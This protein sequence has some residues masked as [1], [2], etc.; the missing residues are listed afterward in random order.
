MPA[1]IAPGIETEV[2]ISEEEIRGGR[3]VAA[4]E[5]RYTPREYQELVIGLLWG[6]AAGEAFVLEHE[7]FAHWAC[8]APRTEDRF[9][10]VTTIKEELE[11]ALEGWRLLR[12][13]DDLVDWKDLL[14]TQPKGSRYE[15]FRHPT[16]DWS[17]FAAISALTD[18]V[19]CFQQEEQLDCSYLPYAEAIQ[20]IYF[21]LEKG[22]AARGRFWLRQLCETDEGRARAQSA[23]DLWW[24]RAL[25]MFGRSESTRQH[26]F[27][28]YRLKTRT[29]EQRR[30]A[31]IDTVGPELQDYGLTVPDPLVGRK[32]L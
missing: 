32:Y 12:Q 28:E 17:E 2:R 1:T 14:P 7:V 20:R 9:M 16:T 25:D 31:Y 10:V 5:L 6:H 29:N 3:N 22:H 4:A 24:P 21:P 18:R 23:V 27:I 26:R 30:Q 8:D 11:H 13:L 15:G 19:G